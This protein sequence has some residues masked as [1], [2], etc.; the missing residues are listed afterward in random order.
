MGVTVLMADIADYFYE[1]INTD[2]KTYKVGGK[3]R[4]LKVL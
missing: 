1:E 2:N 4:D 3:N